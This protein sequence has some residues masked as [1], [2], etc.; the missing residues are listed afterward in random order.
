[1]KVPEERYDEVI[2]VVNS[3]AEVAHNYARDHELNMWFVV[4]TEIPQQV[5]SVIQQIQEKTG[6]RVYNMPKQHEF[7]LGLRFEV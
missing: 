2:D 1:M 3:F 7:F 6:I 4:A 5:T